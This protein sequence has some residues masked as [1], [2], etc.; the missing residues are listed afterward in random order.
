MRVKLLFL[1]LILLCSR[2]VFSQ[3]ETITG[4]VSSQDGQPL[5]GVT[6]Q[7]KNTKQ[8]TITDVG[9][10]F[11]MEKKPA[12]NVL[13]ITSAGYEPKEVRV[14]SEQHLA[15]GLTPSYGSMNTIVVVGYGTQKK[16]D[17]TGAVASISSQKINEV[18]VISP[19]QALQ[20]RVAGVLVDR[21]GNR[22]GDDAK[23]LIRGRRSFKA[24]SDPLFVV[25]GIPVDAGISDI[26]P[27]DIE[28]MEVLKDASATAI[29][30][31]RGAN[32]VILITTKRGKAGKA[33]V[34]YDAY[35]GTETPLRLA[36]LMNAAEFAEYR[37]EA[38]RN[39]YDVNG[40][41]IYPSATPSQS[42]D[43]DLFKQDPLVQQN[44]LNAYDA[45]GVYHPEA[46]KNTDWSSLVLRT[47]FVHNHHISVSGGSDKT[48]IFFSAG[49]IQDKGI[50]K[51]QDF[52]R[53]NV[54]LTIDHEI[55]KAIK[56]GMS[57]YYAF[58]LQNYGSDLYSAARNL[59]PLASPYDSTGKMIFQPGN[60]G[61]VYNPLYDVSGRVDERRKYRYLGSFYTEIK[62]ATGLKY[63]FNFGLD[64]GKYR[65]GEF[66]SAMSTSRA[67]GTA[68]A[69]LFNDI[70]S[71]YNLQNLLYYDTKLNKH[72]FGLTFLQELQTYRYEN[73]EEKASDLPYESQLFYNIGSAVNVLGISSNLSK[74]KLVS[75][76]GRLN[77]GF[78][79]RY[80]LTLSLRADGASVLAEGHNFSYFPSAAFAWRVTQES[81]MRNARLFNDLKLRVGYGGTGN[82]SINPYQTLGSLSQTSYTWNE[83]P[84]NGFRPNLIRNNLLK[85]ETTGQYNVGLDFSLLNSRV[86]GTVDA[87]L[88]KTRDLLLDRQLPTASGFNSITQ[89]VGS[90][91]NRGIEL[92]LSTVNIDSKSG[93]RWTTDFMFYHNDERIESLYKGKID[94]V[95]NKWFIGKPISVYYDYRKI[96]IW[97]NNDKDI[98]QMQSFNTN[99]SNF[100]PGYIKLDDVNGDNKIT[101]ADRVILGTPSPRWTGSFNSTLSYM[102][103]DFSV[104]VYAKQK[105]MIYADKGIQNNGRYNQWKINYYT[106]ANGSND[107]PRPTAALENPDYQST[108]YYE[109]GSFVKIRNITFGY[110]LPEAVLSRIRARSF[111]IYVSAENPYMFTKSTAMDPE[112]TFGVSTPSVRI[113]LAGINIGF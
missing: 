90:T 3:T 75:F 68:Y 87:Y 27:N 84:A 112:N 89:N 8:Y 46:L 50:T 100:K 92:T 53:Y 97:Q 74:N 52:S 85:W 48:K 35:A 49:Y 43:K 14:G 31:S 70:R 77:Y 34:N 15:I 57:S 91:S 44:V 30:G 82:S 109:D 5:Q 67:G 11:K 63:R 113:F 66:Q 16:S 10:N 78:D 111:R 79:S 29:Y 71:N 61:L 83:N 80:L 4:K 73:A 104:F 26:N 81:F 25:D 69:R 99:G 101:P 98:A 12:N 64:Y 86:S 41:S 40:N 65:Q 23:I 108:L 17:V 106:P 94:D 19:A 60:D 103:F 105:F 51:N 9:G 110:K 32:G 7:V 6:V 39:T 56:I 62:L 24:S 59:N 42:L 47:G 36:S 37:R 96:G 2:S 107:Y 58:G 38:F 93:V 1:G 45:N 13:V 95:G 72:S 55:S 54:K 33:S 21:G 76:M 28:S 88:Q 102:G 22:P 20:G 18:P